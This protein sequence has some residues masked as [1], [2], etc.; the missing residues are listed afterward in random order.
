MNEELVKEWVSKAEED[1]Q[2][3]K[4]LSV[5]EFPNAICFHCQQAAEKLLKSILV[6]NNERPPRSHDLIYWKCL[7]HIQS[8]IA[9]SILSIN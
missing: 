3:A 6:Q 4:S 2:V 9:K 8:S 7:I 1:Y 5:D